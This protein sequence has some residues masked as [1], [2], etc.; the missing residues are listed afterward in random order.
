[1]IRYPNVFIAGQL[2]GVEGYMGNIAFGNI[3]ARNLIRMKTGLPPIDPPPE[4]MIGAL[5]H[6]IV[7]NDGDDVQPVKANFGIL[8]PLE[9]PKRSKKERAIQ[10]VERALRYYDPGRCWLGFDS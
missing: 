10:Y 7:G 8:P 3:A 9:A 6:A 2:A 1:M 5:I 4:T